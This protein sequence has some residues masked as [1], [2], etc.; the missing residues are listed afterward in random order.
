MFL[1]IL[2]I[3]QESFF[4]KVAVL[5]A[6]NFIKKRL[7]HRCFPMKF[8]KFLRTTSLKSICERLLLNLFKK[9]LQH[10]CFPVNFVTNSRTSTLKSNYELLVL[11]HQCWGFFL[12]KLQAWRSGSLYQYYKETL[13]LVFF[14][15]F[16]VIFKKAF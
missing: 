4:N 11:K 10:R 14:C 5:K 13:P 1:K 7:W 12:M 8:A 3:S 6:W 9:R 2:Q 15:E 16:C